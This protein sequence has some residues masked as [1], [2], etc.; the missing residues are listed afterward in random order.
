MSLR[1]PSRPY[2]GRPGLILGMI[3]DEVGFK[4]V[5]NASKIEIVFFSEADATL[6]Y[7]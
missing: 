1:T 6:C 5:R 7:P 2:A 3:H 4:E